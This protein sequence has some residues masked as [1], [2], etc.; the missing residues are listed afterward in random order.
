MNRQRIA[1]GGRLTR[2]LGPA[3]MLGMA[4]MLLMVN[5]VAAMPAA[6]VANPA[7]PLAGVLTGDDI[8]G[9]LIAAG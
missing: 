3:V 4:A 6:S 8:R 2:L 9:P 5:P 1:R 7:H